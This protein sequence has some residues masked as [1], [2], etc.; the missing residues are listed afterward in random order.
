MFT[1]FTSRGSEG[2][3]QNCIAI[4]GVFYSSS[5]GNC[6]IPLS[7]SSPAGG[8]SI[9]GGGGMRVGGGEGVRCKA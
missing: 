6:S 1:P 9:L 2:G 3:K 4:L 7:S 8:K 5:N